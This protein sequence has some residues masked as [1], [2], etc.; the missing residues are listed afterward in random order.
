MDNEKDLTTQEE[1]PKPKKTT[2]KKT[3]KETAT[4]QEPTQQETQEQQISDAPEQTT[5]TTE[6]PTW[7][8]YNQVQSVE[9][10]SSHGGSNKT[11]SVRRNAQK[12][13][14]NAKTQRASRRINRRK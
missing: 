6:N 10:K 11:P 2:K 3:T 13:I 1:A 12:R 9:T 14:R 8:F 5:S 4:V 7:N